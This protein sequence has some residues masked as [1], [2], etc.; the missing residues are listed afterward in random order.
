MTK[1]TAPNYVPAVKY[2]APPKPQVSHLPQL[3]LDDLPSNVLMQT[4]GHALLLRR[5]HGSQ[6][7]AQFVAW[8]ANRLPVSMID[9]AGNVHVDRRIGPTSRTLF[10]AHTD[11]VHHSGGPNSVRIDGTFWRADGAALGAD[12]GAGV[13]L[14]CH[15]IER[16]VPGYYIFFRG[17]ECGGVGSSWLAENMEGLLEEFD[18]AVAFD[19]AGYHDVIT[20]QS[21]GRCCSNEFAEELSRQMTAD[22]FSMA[23]APCDGGVYTDT[24]EFIRI[25]PECTNLSVGYKNQHGEWEEQDVAFLVQMAQQLV[26]VDWDSLP[27]ERNPKVYESRYGGFGRHGRSRSRSYS[28]KDLDA[29]QMPHWMDGTANTSFWSDYDTGHDDKDPENEIALTTIEM[30][31]DGTNRTGLRDLIAE[32]ASPDHPEL[33]KKMIQPSKL[34]DEVAEYLYDALC[35]GWDVDAVMQ[36]AFEMTTSI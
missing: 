18:R 17:E 19:R 36:D 1:V 20:H 11:T 31:L 33:A 5:D 28:S 16:G 7:E 22:D 29:V 32:Y 21:G 2:V 27:V 26:Q 3:R 8:L 25:I 34:T 30:F 4:L 23:Y 13:A 24:A 15:M 35:D 14:M 10:T 6:T 12:D 9:G